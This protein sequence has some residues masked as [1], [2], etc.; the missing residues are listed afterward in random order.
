VPRD[1]PD[2]RLGPCQS[3]GCHF[4]ASISC[5]R[6]HV[7]LVRPQMRLERRVELQLAARVSSSNAAK[8]DREPFV[9]YI[10]SSM[11]SHSLS[12]ACSL[13]LAED[14]VLA[15]GQAC[16]TAAAFSQVLVTR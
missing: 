16:T 15:S 1:G 5:P 11:T 12:W 8:S 6:D 7:E 10:E 13:S 14:P 2:L 4:E 3:I 9:R